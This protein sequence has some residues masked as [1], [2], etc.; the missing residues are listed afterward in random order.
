M[1]AEVTTK[2]MVIG[3]VDSHT[4]DFQ[5]PPY[6]VRYSELTVWVCGVCFGS[7]LCFLG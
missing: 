3:N 5:N 1:L 2:N 6:R 4:S 7:I